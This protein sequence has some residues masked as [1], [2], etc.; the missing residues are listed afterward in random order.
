VPVVRGIHRART[1]KNPESVVVVEAV[2]IGPLVSHDGQYVG[3][4]EEV[5]VVEG[6]H[7]AGEI[8]YRHRPSSR[9]SSGLSTIGQCPRENAT[10][11][12]A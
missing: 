7:E 4:V 8:A 9:V 10:L 1:E 5:G 3:V 11:G 12:I 6:D 2:E